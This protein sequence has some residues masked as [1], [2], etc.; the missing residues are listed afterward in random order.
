[1]KNLIN[2]AIEELESDDNVSVMMI[3]LNVNR[4]NN[5]T[6][7]DVDTHFLRRLARSETLGEI[8][9]LETIKTVTKEE[10]DDSLRVVEVVKEERQQQ[11]CIFALMEE[12]KVNVQ[13][14]AAVDINL[15]EQVIQLSKK[16]NNLKEKRNII[17]KN[18]YEERMMKVE[19]LMSNQIE[20]GQQE[21]EEK[22]TLPVNMMV[23]LENTVV[24]DSI[25]NINESEVA[26]KVVVEHVIQEKA[27]RGTTKMKRT[28]AYEIR[29]NFEKNASINQIEEKVTVEQ[30]IEEAEGD[31]GE[32]KEEM[33]IDAIGENSVNKGGGGE[34][35]SLPIG[36]VELLD[37]DSGDT[38]YH[39]EE[40]STTIWDRPK[41]TKEQLEVVVNEGKALAV[42]QEP[43]QEEKVAGKEKEQE[44]DMK[45]LNIS[46]NTLPLKSS[47]HEIRAVF[48]PSQYQRKRRATDAVQRNDIT[49]ESSFPIN[50]AAAASY[51]SSSSSSSSSTARL[52]NESRR[53]SLTTTAGDKIGNKY[54][55]PS[56]HTMVKKLN[57]Q[58][59]NAR[60]AARNSNNKQ[61][62]LIN[63]T[64]TLDLE[65]TAT[66][67]IKCRGWMLK[68][69][70][71][72]IFSS[73]KFR[74]R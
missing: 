53:R 74:K 60:S 71:G 33:F 15:K 50:A 3:R 38:Y 19:H 42:K 67:N 68:R 25:V 1:L 20:G 21:E 5:K 2:T 10:D 55:T 48:S 22:E 66:I 16:S 39:H 18:S 65:D 35:V 47:F 46:L 4:S 62:P 6:I 43:E 8:I 63:R 23:A 34:S 12:N 13:E 27:E 36:W 51:I 17:Q 14:D 64:S 73:S 30:L 49:K 44:K 58:A 28:S 32:E 56:V 72:G 11:V 57:S 70:Q 45:K 69:G 24:S 9:E 37:H 40:S 61:T 7:H 29:L 31:E 26:S 54:N 41:K 52:M 59:P